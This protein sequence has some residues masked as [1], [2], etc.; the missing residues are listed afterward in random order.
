MDGFSSLTWC[1]RQGNGFF[2][3]PLDLAMVARCTMAP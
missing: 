1:Q 3:T 2:R